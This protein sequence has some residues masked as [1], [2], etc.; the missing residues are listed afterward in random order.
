MRM[1]TIDIVAQCV[2]YGRK[3]IWYGR[4]EVGATSKAYGLVAIMHSDR[5]ARAREMIDTLKRRV[6]I[7][8]TDEESP[9]QE[10]F[11]RLYAGSFYE[12]G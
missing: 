12:L 5:S 3:G 2:D 1:R 8:G 11:S 10:W 4:V 9:G 6:E 7:G